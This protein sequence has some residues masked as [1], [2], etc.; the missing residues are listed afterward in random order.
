MYIIMI[1]ITMCIYI[2]TYIHIH[3]PIHM[4]THHK[5]TL[6]IHIYTCGRQHISVSTRWYIQNHKITTE[7]VQAPEWPGAEWV[8]CSEAFIPRL[9]MPAAAG[10][11][12]QVMVGCH[13]ESVGLSQVSCGFNMIARDPIALWHDDV[14]GLKHHTLIMGLWLSD[15]KVIGSLGYHPNWPTTDVQYRCSN[16]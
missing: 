11:V 10:A 16:G 12:L 9:E 8:I 3:L 6:N 14:W 1:D 2:Y 7:C 15:K 5:Y 4:Y 13:S